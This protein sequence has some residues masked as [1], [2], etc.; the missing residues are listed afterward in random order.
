M[1]TMKNG[2]KPQLKGKKTHKTH[3]MRTVRRLKVLTEK[4]KTMKSHTQFQSL[5]KEL[6]TA[7]KLQ[8]GLMRLGKLT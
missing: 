3:K 2:K 8:L 4:T 1:L 6:L 5:K 7:C